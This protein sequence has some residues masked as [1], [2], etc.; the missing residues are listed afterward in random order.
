MGA[1][2]AGTLS[3]SLV[4]RG[5]KYIHSRQSCPVEK[6]DKRVCAYFSV[7]QIVIPGGTIFPHAQGQPEQVQIRIGWSASDHRAF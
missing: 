7:I 6:V 2:L 4:P 5:N 1:A 3:E